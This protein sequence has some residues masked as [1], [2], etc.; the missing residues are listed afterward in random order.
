MSCNSSPQISFRLIYVIG[1]DLLIL[2]LNQVSAFRHSYCIVFLPLQVTI[3]ENNLGCSISFLHLS[4]ICPRA[5]TTALCIRRFRDFA[6]CDFRHYAPLTPSQRNFDHLPHVLW[7]HDPDP[8][9]IQRLWLNRD[10]TISAFLMHWVLCLSMSR[11][12]KL[13]YGVWSTIQI[14]S[15]FNDYD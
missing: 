13:R 1:W 12:A 3:P 2:P 10:F 4:L 6:F 11:F 8:I 5:V 15:L 14:W 7:S 9:L